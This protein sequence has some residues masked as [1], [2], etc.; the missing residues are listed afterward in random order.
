[1]REIWTG[2]RVSERRPDHVGDTLVQLSAHTKILALFSADVH[3]LQ[4][5]SSLAVRVVYY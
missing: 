1:M 4:G 5:V 3:L 2:M